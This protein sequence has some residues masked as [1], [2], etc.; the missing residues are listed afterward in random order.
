[1]LYPHDYVDAADA[2]DRARVVAKYAHR[3]RRLACL[4]WRGGGPRV[5]LVL[6][7]GD[8]KG[9][10]VITDWQRMIFADVGVDGDAL[11]DA[12]LGA[13]A[14]DVAALRS[15]VADPGA[16]HQRRRPR[17]RLANHK[18]RRRRV[19]GH[20]TD[21]RLRARGQRDT[22]TCNLT[23]SVGDLGRSASLVACDGAS[24]LFPATVMR[25]HSHATRVRFPTCGL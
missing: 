24:D 12:V 6:H 9:E 10:E 14:R 13:R 23:F 17:W 16:A 15:F 19:D 11:V 20:P 3:Y 22:K 21:R 2:V 7:P 25:R 4:L 5:Y 18:A 8:E 1:M